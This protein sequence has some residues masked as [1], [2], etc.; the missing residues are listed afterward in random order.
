MSEMSI[1]QILGSKD[2]KELSQ[3]G[4]WSPQKESNRHKVTEQ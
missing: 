1:I 2:L 4:N 3:M